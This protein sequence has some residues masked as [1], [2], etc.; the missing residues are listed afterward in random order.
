MD[1]IKLCAK[2]QKLCVCYVT[3][4]AP[5]EKQGRGGGGGNRISASI[6]IQVGQH[7]RDQGRNKKNLKETKRLEQREN[8]DKSER[9]LVRG[10]MSDLPEKPMKTR[11]NQGQYPAI[12]TI[13]P[14]NH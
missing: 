11:R 13:C 10:S 12:Q 5:Q 3:P 6:Q 1:M 14:T 8:T 2:V 9:L 4:N 7:I